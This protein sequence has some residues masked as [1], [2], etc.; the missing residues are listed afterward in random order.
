MIKIGK[1]NPNP[2]SINLAE[3]IIVIN[4]IMKTIDIKISL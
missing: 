2:I 3:N 1:N 4:I